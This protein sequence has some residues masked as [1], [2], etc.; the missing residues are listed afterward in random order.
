MCYAFKRHAFFD[1]L[2]VIHDKDSIPPLQRPWPSA[3]VDLLMSSFVKHIPEHPL[4]L[5]LI[6]L[7]SLFLLN[8]HSKTHPYKV[9]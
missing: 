5:S 6:S 4:K 2:L 7:Y 3:A 9:K 1:I 8:E